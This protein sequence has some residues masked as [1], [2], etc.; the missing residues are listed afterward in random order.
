MVASGKM[1]YISNALYVDCSRLPLIAVK[2]FSV[3]SESWAYN[4]LPV[5]GVLPVLDDRG[6]SVAQQSED[7]LRPRERGVVR[8]GVPPQRARSDVRPLREE[9]LDDLRAVRL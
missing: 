1:Y 6:P 9:E 2:S 3:F 7:L 5:V 4:N 8:G